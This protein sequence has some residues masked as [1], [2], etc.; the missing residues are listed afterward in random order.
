MAERTITLRFETEEQAKAFDNLIH[1]PT[2]LLP[3]GIRTGVG[4]GDEDDRT[5]DVGLAIEYLVARA[6]TARTGAEVQVGSDVAIQVAPRAFLAAPRAAEAMKKNRTSP[7]AA[8]A[9]AA[10]KGAIR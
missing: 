9:A 1:D 6:L 8:K 2:G 4:Y 10:F 3:H 7:A 5:M